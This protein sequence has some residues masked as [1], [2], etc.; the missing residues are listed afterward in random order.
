M[1]HLF[2]A[3]TATVAMLASCTSE[4]I[5]ERPVREE[6]P[7]PIEFSSNTGYMTRATGAD[8]ADLLN[9]QFTVF[10]RKYVNGVQTNVF[11]KEDPSTHVVTG[12]HVG[13]TI[14]ETET[15]KTATWDYVTAT[16]EVRYW[17][18][19]ASQYTFLAFS[20][21][22]TT[23]KV[24]YNFVSDPSNFIVSTVN[25][26]ELSKIYTA[27]QVDV[28][29]A[30]FHHKV[31]FQFSSA[32]SKVRAAFFNAIPGYDVVIDGF[33]PS[34]DAENTGDNLVFYNTGSDQ[35]FRT[36]ASYKIALATG[37]V[38]EQA[39]P[40][41]SATFTFGTSAVGE[42]IGKEIAQARFD[43]VVDGKGVYA[44]AMPMPANNK[45]LNFKMKYRLVS[46]HE[47]INR[48]S[49]V[50]IPAEY[51][52]WKSNHAYTYFFRITDND[53]HPI[54]FTA[55]VV[56]FATNETITTADGEQ[57]I[58]ITTYVE[59]STVM[60][61]PVYKV[62]DEIHVAITNATLST[63]AGAVKVA[64]TTDSTI[65]G[66]NADVIADDQYTVPVTVVGNGNYKFTANQGAG[67]Y[68][69]K[70]SYTDSKSQAKVAFKVVTVTGSSSN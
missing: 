50:T 58:N 43:N 40:T 47:S 6:V 14:S 59:G 8:A 46:Q 56:D 20:D 62:G 33:Y 34:K 23:K 69:I 19:E 51:A 28:E 26:T 36:S 32:A 24:S 65:N 54:T 49:F 67:K 70:V 11:G 30:K 39:D 3:A 27:P 37:A 38:V 16:E 25:V 66:S 63:G 21:A 2:I 29:K 31:G 4:V 41:T 1:R 35:S 61:T 52:Q 5:P 64:H 42:T 53:M 15:G 22:N 12:V 13:A 44:W 60:T 55:E 68:V 9:H 57:E 18:E 45:D 48:E 17:D 7:S 10:G